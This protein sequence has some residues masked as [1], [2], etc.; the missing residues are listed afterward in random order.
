VEWARAR[1]TSVHRTDCASVADTPSVAWRESSTY[2]ASLSKLLN[3]AP[4]SSQDRCTKSR[5]TRAITSSMI[6]VRSRL[7]RYSG[8]IGASL[9]IVRR[10]PMIYNNKGLRAAN[11]RVEHL[12]RRLN[13]L[14]LMREVKAEPCSG[15][16]FLVRPSL[17]RAEALRTMRGLKNE[18]SLS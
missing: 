7:N 2:A 16:F 17:S 14:A 8:E 6:A 3:F 9:R 10:S 1:T 18:E 4:E 11:S 13:V 15:R 5:V 12:G